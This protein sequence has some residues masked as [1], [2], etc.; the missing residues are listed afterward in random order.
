MRLNPGMNVIVAH[1]AILMIDLAAA[2]YLFSA[3]SKIDPKKRTTNAGRG[4]QINDHP[5]THPHPALADLNANRQTSALRW[6]GSAAND[7]WFCVLAQ[8]NFAGTEWQVCQERNESNYQI[9]TWGR[10]GLSKS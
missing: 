8:E 9:S 4:I 10:H 5:L 7:D 1:P 6:R 2:G 3:I